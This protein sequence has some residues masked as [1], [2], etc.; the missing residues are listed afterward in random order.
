MTVERSITDTLQ[1]TSQE[2]EY[3]YGLIPGKSRDEQ[4]QTKKLSGTKYKNNWRE[5]H[6]GKIITPQKWLYH[7][8]THESCPTGDSKSL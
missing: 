1:K 2:N 7:A 5:F 3:R 4:P 6:V 8:T